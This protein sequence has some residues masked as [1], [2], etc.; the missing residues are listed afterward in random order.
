MDFGAKGAINN[1]PV[2]N[3]AILVDEESAA[4]RELLAFHIESFYRDGGGL[5]RARDRKFVLCEHPRRTNGA[6]ACAKQNHDERFAKAYAICFHW[7]P[8]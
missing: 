7:L 5:M 4:P 8:I 1:V 6:E 3:N 2:G